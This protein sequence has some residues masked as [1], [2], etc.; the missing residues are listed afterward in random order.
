MQYSYFSTYGGITATYGDYLACFSRYELQNSASILSG[1][2][3]DPV[4]GYYTDCSYLRPV[5][6]TTTKLGSRTVHFYA[7]HLKAQAYTNGIPGNDDDI[8]KRRAQAHALEEWI[9]AQ[10]NP[11]TD[12]IVILGDANTALTGDTYHP[13]DDFADDSTLG[14]LCLKSD[15][16]GNTAN[17]FS[18]MNV[19]LL[20]ADAWTHSVYNSRLDHIILSPAAVS[21]YAAG[22]LKIVTHDANDPADHY[23]VLL[24]IEE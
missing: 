24:R 4:S 20:D 9:K 3:T 5:I 23:P 8:K 10:H 22:S 7:L 1:T 12:L 2:Y 17:D 18:P 13:G 16:P 15:N 11:E 14:M 19:T 21:L 6:Y